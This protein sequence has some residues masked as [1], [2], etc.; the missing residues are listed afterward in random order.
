VRLPAIAVLVCALAPLARARNPASDALPGNPAEPVEERRLVVALYDGMGVDQPLD[1]ADPVHQLIELPL[2]HLGMVVRRWDIRQGPPPEAWMAAPRAILTRFESTGDPPDWLWPWLEEHGTR[3]GVRVIHLE[4]F[5]PLQYRGA[6]L[7]ATRLAAWLARF[8]LAYEDVFVEGPIG[9][10]VTAR[11]PEATGFE[12]DGRSRACH[13]GPRNTSDANRVWLETESAFEKGVVRTPVV[14]GPWGGI[15]LSPWVLD[16]GDRSDA[17]RWHLDPFAFFTEALGLRGVPAPHPSVLNGRRM[18]V[19]HVD[20]DGFE[21][22]STVESGAYA[23][24][25]FLDEV[26]RRYELPATVSIIVASLTDDLQP[27]E[28]NDRMR[29]ARRIFAEPNVEPGTHTVLHPLRWDQGETYYHDLKH[30]EFDP[31]AEVRESIRFINR[32]LAPPDKPCRMVLWSG[33]CNPAREPVVAA[34][35]EGCDNINGGVFRWDATSDSV[36]FVSPWGNWKGD[37]F[38][39]YPGAANE[40]EFDG[41]YDTM[42]GAF[43]HIDTTIERCGSPRI[44]KPANVYCHFYSA[45]RPARLAALKKLLDRWGVAEPTAPVFASRYCEAVR[46]AVYGARVLRAGPDRWLLRQ[47]GACRTVRLDGDPREVDFAASRGVIGSHRI[48]GQLYVSLSA[49]DAELVLA[50]DPAP[51]LHLEQANHDV[52]QV[53]MDAARLAWVAQGF[54][55]RVAVLAGLPAGADVEFA[56][57]ESVESLSADADGRVELGWHQ[58]GP[59]RVVVTVP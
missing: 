27:A 55:R 21:S 41:F 18:F 26:I 9:I 59:L 17:R 16:P 51:R 14:T 49:P 34:R 8:G 53:E 38:Q 15:A 47:M 42:P 33:T 10:R 20:G 28:V 5:G 45:E 58:E 25:V 22:L 7:D 52:Q 24:K 19:F 23:A 35:E 32:W 31:V 12:A 48:D 3:P 56:A 39:V 4:E 46:D 43:G 6:E 40:N 44:L 29:L 37:E 2:N 54:G 50:S 13:R 1:F 36:A 11:V 30:Y 57:G